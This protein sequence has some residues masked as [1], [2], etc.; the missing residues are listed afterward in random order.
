MAVLIALGVNILS[1]GIVVY[2]GLSFLTMVIVGSLLMTLGSVI[3]LR[4]AYPGIME[5]MTSKEWSA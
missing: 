4:N 2:F 3:F 1:S 5:S